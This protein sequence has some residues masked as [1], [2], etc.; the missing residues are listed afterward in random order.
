MTKPILA[1]V[2][3][4]SFILA[5]Q[6]KKDHNFSGNP[7]FP[8]WY[9]DPE[10]TIF[11]NTY[12]IF[13]TFS[14]DSGEQEAAANFTDYQLKIRQNTINPQYLEQI[15]LDAFSSKDLTKWVK[16]AHVLDVKN[17]AWAGYAVWAPSITRKGD[18][19]YLFF[20]ANDIQNN[21]QPGGTGVAVADRPEGPYKDHLGKPLVSQ[22]YNDAQPIDQFAFRDTNGKYYL[23][24]GASLP[25]MSQRQARV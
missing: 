2:I 19:Y 8:G 21:Q 24:Y 1:V 17:I 6:D 9:A 18:K 25:A 23:I 15:F 12:W 10:G 22:F 3:L 13:P 7:V 11:G 20:G 16:H 5:A 14:D 4:N